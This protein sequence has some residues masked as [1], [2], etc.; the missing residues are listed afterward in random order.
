MKFACLMRIHPWMNPIV[1]GNNW[2]NRTT[3]MEENVPQNQFFGFYS[4]GME[5]FM[6]KTYKQY[7]VPHSPQKRFNSFLESDADFASKR[8]MS[9]QK[10]FFAVILENIFF[11][12]EKIV[13]WKIF[14]TSFPTK[15]VIL[16][17]VTRRP[18]SLKTD[19]PSRKWFFVVFS[20]N[21][22][23]LNPRINIRSSRA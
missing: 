16:I 20:E 22:A 11:F 19:M 2:P 6:E 4:A 13:Q 9:P 17:F 12:F 7:L 14:K 1:F 18:L 5:F 15:K 23:F 3:D 8:I 10:L 21:V